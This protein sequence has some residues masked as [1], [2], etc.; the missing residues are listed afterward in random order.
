MVDTVLSRLACQAGLSQ[1]RPGSASAS[2]SS[3]TGRPFQAEPEGGPG[4]GR[5]G[6]TPQFAADSDRPAMPHHQPHRGPG[7]GPTALF[8]GPAAVIVVTTP[9]PQLEGAGPS[10]LELTAMILT[11]PAGMI[12]IAGSFRVTV[13]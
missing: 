11:Y 10:G 3:A 2:E 9:F 12:R 13:H 5:I 1:G 7:P 6:M 4:M 8:D